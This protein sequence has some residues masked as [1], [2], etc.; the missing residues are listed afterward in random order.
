MI[1]VIK[2]R[3]CKSSETGMRRRR[4]RHGNCF[5]YYFQRL[6][7]WCL[8]ITKVTKGFRTSYIF[9]HSF[10]QGIKRALEVGR[11][12]FEIT[13]TTFQVVLIVR[14]DACLRLASEVVHDKY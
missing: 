7:Q 4:I 8:H 1:F 13:S 3:G 10:G 14:V 5:M 6:C 2:E 11:V 9:G 12:G